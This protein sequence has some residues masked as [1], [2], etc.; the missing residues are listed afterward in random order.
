MHHWY[1]TIILVRNMT[2]RA[3]RSDGHPHMDIVRY[4]TMVVAYVYEDRSLRLKSSKITTRMTTMITAT[5][6]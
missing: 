5:A 4:M 2:T 1:R 6:K 3:R